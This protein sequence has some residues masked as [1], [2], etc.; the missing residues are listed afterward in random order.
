GLY[1][2]DET[3]YYGTDPNVADSDGDGVSDGEEVFNGTDPGD[4]GTG[5]SG[6]NSSGTTSGS[7]GTS[8]GS[9]G[10]TSGSSGQS[11]GTSTGDPRPDT[12]GD[13]LYDDDET[14]YYGTD[15]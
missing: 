1:D 12:D 8:S 15:P 11:S 13:G 6:T 7:S 2:D 9:S 14:D 4:G 5:S 3:D 10:T